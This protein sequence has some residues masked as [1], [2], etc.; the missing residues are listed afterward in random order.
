MI[1]FDLICGNFSRQ[2][3]RLVVHQQKL[4]EGFDEKVDKLLGDPV[5]NTE[6]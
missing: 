2:K 3:I 5:G 6:Q 4:D 1:K